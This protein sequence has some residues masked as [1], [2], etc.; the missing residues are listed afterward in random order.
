MDKEKKVD[1][2]FRDYLDRLEKG[3]ALDLKKLF[4]RHG[5]L[6][7][8]L[9]ERFWT[10]EEARSVFKA[11]LDEDEEV[12]ST[13][14]DPELFF[15]FRDD[16][17]EEFGRRI[18]D[19]TLLK[20]IGRGT[21]GVVFLA[22][23]QA[24]DRLVA[25]KLLSPLRHKSPTA[26]ERFRREVAALG[27]LRHANIVSIL[28]AG[29]VEGIP[30]FAMELVSGVQLDDVIADLKRKG[31]LA[32]T[33]NTIKAVIDRKLPGYMKPFV[34]PSESGDGTREIDE[35]FSRPYVE[36][37]CR[38][39][40]QLAEALEHAHAQG[41]VHRDV[42]P[43]NVLIDVHGRC[44]LSDFG[45]ARELGQE[46]LTKTGEL[47]GTPYYSAPEQLAGKH[48]S[49]DRRA[50][51]YSLGITLYELLCLTVPFTGE[52]TQQVFNQILVK[53][54]K[55]PGAHNAG[56]PKE[57]ETIVF[58]CLE[59]DPDHRYQTAGELAEDLKAFLEFR[60]IKARPTGPIRNAI[61]LIRRQRLVSA[62]LSV[63]FVAVLVLAVFMAKIHWEG[64]QYER[65]RAVRIEQEID[66]IETAL[67]DKALIDAKKGLQRFQA[68][69]S[70]HPKLEKL[71]QE[72][73]M[74]HCELKLQIATQLETGLDVLKKQSSRTKTTLSRLEKKNYRRYSSEAERI[75]A[76]AQKRRLKELE[77]EMV[78]SEEKII[79]AM[80]D[81]RTQAEST[82][83]RDHPPVLERFAEHY[84]D[85][86]R[87]KLGEGDEI[88]MAHYAGLV[89]E[90]DRDG[91]FTAELEG[92][93]KLAIEGTPG[94][95]AWLFRYESYRKVSAR[96]GVDRLV[97]VPSR[98]NAADGPVE[99]VPGYFAGDPC[100]RVVDGGLTKL[101]AG[102]LILS[103]NGEPAAE[104]LFVEEVAEGSAAAGAGVRP[105]SRIAA[106]EEV[107]GGPNAFTLDSVSL[108]AWQRFTAGTE[109]SITVSSGDDRIR[110]SESEKRGSLTERFGLRA[111]PASRLLFETVTPLNITIR[112]LR[113]GKEMTVT[114]HEGEVAGIR[115]EIAACPLICSDRNSLGPL[116]VKPFVCSPGSYLILIRKEGMEDLRLPVM[117]SRH[118]SAL[119]KTTLVRGN[120][121][122]AGTS[123]EG[124]VRVVSTGSFVIGGDRDAL[125]S[126]DRH[127][128]EV[129]EFWIARRE[130]TIG[131]WFEFINDPEINAEIDRSLAQGRNIFFPRYSRLEETD[132]PSG[133]EKVICLAQRNPGPGGRWMSTRWSNL[134][135]PV[136]GIS[137]EDI[138]HFLAWKNRRSRK[139]GESWEYNLPSQIEWEK[140]ARGMDG[141]FFPWG[142]RF[143]FT[144][145]QSRYSY[146]ESVIPKNYSTLLLRLEPVLSYPIDE[147][148]YGV[149]DLAGS[150]VEWNRDTYQRQ[151]IRGGQYDGQTADLFRAAS[152]DNLKADDTAHN[153]GFRL[154]ARPVAK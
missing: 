41:I 105:F 121:V 5:D 9:W 138:T 129:G 152:R 119:Q 100:L 91:R 87:R 34:E 24:T 107:G 104:G 67:E 102:D 96:A 35:I 23:Q 135:T 62:A 73:A 94:A 66:L 33:G 30:Y 58:K 140:A 136:V 17:G 88:G 98:G 83:K 101:E 43:S 86:W 75:E 14:Q 111:I 20:E 108:F 3:E 31:P 26:R 112:A 90:Y 114:I 130:V 54:P 146:P 117:I 78:E 48:V 145:C 122:P 25:L 28:T 59:K 151:S 11:E 81:A 69:G 89:Q 40:I 60:P 113:K 85:H 79:Y 137:F 77:L 27:R 42:K 110:L 99:I 106:V 141:R 47:V 154:V 2:V 57:L 16:R 39:A 61:K 95:R 12:A 124:F 64:R 44:R 15:A 148:V 123:P 55:P 127:E 56:V 142:L 150:V 6:E 147:S 50:D 52:T 38:F 116:T 97:P 71:R 29:D 72:I 53:N 125:W 45:L 128:E 63:A 19:F 32:I 46:S 118:K 131:E 84:M 133:E 36:A 126:D 65:A 120:L 82:G 22:R 132:R 10:W 134:D 115:S 76:C 143:D 153:L 80:N 92:Q 74:L 109:C 51:V 139:R 70:T 13:V 37:A 18:G 8:A 149:R 21:M 103:F 49:L 93:G 68:I 7:E 144:F 1:K 4:S